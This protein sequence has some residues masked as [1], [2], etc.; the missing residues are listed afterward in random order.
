MTRKAPEK[1]ENARILAQKFFEQKLAESAIDVETA[2]LCALT[3]VT[4]DEFTQYFNLSNPSAG[5]LIPY[6]D[7]EGRVCGNFFRLRRI[8]PHKP[9]YVQPSD[10]SNHAYLPPFMDWKAIAEDPNQPI[11]ITEGEFKAIKGCQEQ[12]AV[13]GLGG[14][15]SFR[16]DRAT[17]QLVAELEEF[18]W[19]GRT[20]YI[21][22]DSDAVGKPQVA[23]AENALCRLLTAKG[24]TP[25]VLRLPDLRGLSKTGLDDFLS[26]RGPEGL[27]EI[28]AEAIPFKR[29]EAL[30]EMNEEVVYIKDP[31]L[32]VEVKTAQCIFCLRN[33]RFTY[34]V[35]IVGNIHRAY[36]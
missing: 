33:L 3:P 20:V 12:F 13:V 6:F 27:V 18:V 31:G 17:T 22:Y 34:C 10:S 32:I 36:A 26:A 25:S 1:S 24:A 14:V 29:A 2:E 21:A 8:P 7:L 19:A 15:W 11:Y 4:A 28:T 5:V 16:S 30:L 23:Q 35:A 9:K